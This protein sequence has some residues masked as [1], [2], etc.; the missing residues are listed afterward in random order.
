MAN[1]PLWKAHSTIRKKRKRKVGA[2]PWS[3]F[4]IFIPPILFCFILSGKYALLAAMHTIPRLLWAKRNEVETGELSQRVLAVW[5]GH[6][7]TAGCLSQSS[8]QL[9][10]THRLHLCSG[11]PARDTAGQHQPYSWQCLWLLGLAWRGRREW[12]EQ[13]SAERSRKQCCVGAGNREEQIKCPTCQSVRVAV[14]AGQAVKVQGE[15]HG[16]EEPAPLGTLGWQGQGRNGGTGQRWRV[17]RRAVLAQMPLGGTGSSYNP[18]EAKGQDLKHIREC[19]AE[20]LYM[21][22]H[23]SRRAVGYPKLT[24]KS[25]Q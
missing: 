8:F 20:R 16:P 24:Y 6:A 1:L 9:P 13:T 4:L 17:P 18:E 22:E 7:A 14:P 23:S 25:R 3:I 2:D 10:F 15:P 12:T 19:T 5:S 11:E 21:G